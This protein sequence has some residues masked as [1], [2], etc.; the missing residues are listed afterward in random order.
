[1][2]KIDIKNDVLPHVVAI[3]VFLIVTVSFFAPV[4]FENKTISQ[5]DIKQGAGLSKD[6]H[7][8]REATGKEGLWAS[9]AF[10]GMPAYLINIEWSNEPVSLLKKIFSLFLPHPVGNIFI[11]FLAYYILLLTFGVRPWLA[12]A[13]ALAFGLS[14]YV[15]IGVSAGHNARVGAIAFMPLVM[16]GIHLVFTDRKILGFGV[17]GAGLA[18]QLRENHLQI[19]YYLA[20]I[21]LAYGIVQLVLAVREKKLADFLKNI[22]ILILAVLIAVGSFFG[23]F[24][25]ISEYTKYSMRGGSELIH[26]GETK[27]EN[28]LTKQYAFDYNYG[29]WEPLTLLVPQF[30]GGTSMRLFVEDQNSASYKALVSS[31]DPKANQLA[32]VTSHYWGPQ[33]GGSGGPYYG[34]AIVFFLFVV[35][36]LFA[37]KKYVWW[38]VPLSVLSILL[39][40]GDSF[41][42]FNYFMFDYFPGLN[43]FRSVNFALVIILFSMP[44]LGFIG[45]EKI[46][47]KEMSKEIKRKLIIAFSIA[48]GICL[49]LLLFGGMG[50]FM[51]DGE[52]QLPVWLLIAL[53]EDRLGLLRSDA[54]RSLAFI[55]VVFVLLWLN[56]PRKLSMIGFCAVLTLAM[57]IDLTVV[58]RR[59][60]GKSNFHRKYE[61]NFSASPAD[62]A[63]LADKT[64]YRVLDVQQNPMTDSRAS[65]Y[66]HS[67]GGY[68]G[69]KI[70]RYK[71]LYDSGVVKDT[72]KLFREARTN[73]FDFGSY[74]VLNMLNTKYIMYGPEAKS[75][76][77]NPS[78]NGNAWFV[79]EVIQV[80]SANEELKETT[81]VN[82]RKTAVIDESK[83]SV[84]PIMAD[85]SGKIQLLEVKP[86]YL[87]YESESATNGLAVFSEIYYPKGWHAAIDG[88][89]VPIL[90]ADYVL[91]ALEVP[92]GKHTI[93][94]KFEPKPY[95]IGN[96]ITMASSWVLLL[97]VLASLGWSIRKG[98]NQD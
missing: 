5:Y 12:I 38:L 73:G 81:R 84:H 71:E 70:M 50:S 54:F 85:S 91:R 98:K 10:S 46:L 45:L 26:P 67:L 41:A 20:L 80:K 69:A 77:V 42:T 87:K 18:L 15:I 74:G 32:N 53:Q 36:I 66:H 56:A 21:I 83:F 92:S 13:G 68:H 8:Y 72:D 1:M 58:D 86:P 24:W 37:D 57:I 25:G 76:L 51:R 2:K 33:R 29:I 4:F 23:Q 35:G 64:D 52:G 30:Y 59:Y 48:G 78:A 55:A 49:L 43:K 96:K 88:Q 31:G 44:L 97:V 94:F 79:K 39:S 65:T 82:T 60:F 47:S 3:L 75:V 93:E 90:R 28:G 27:L 62:E 22:G 11:A 95:V 19:T 61:G 63:I 89:E 34:G 7:D 9:S 17:T 14:S 6:L 40:W 16:A